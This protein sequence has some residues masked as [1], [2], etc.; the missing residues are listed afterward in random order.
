MPPSNH[1][2][3]VRT[4]VELLQG[5]PDDP[6]VSP[7]LQ[8]SFKGLPPALVQVC[9]MDP[10]RDDGLL[11]AEKLTKAGVRTRLQK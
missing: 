11:Y 3:R 1:A 2:E 4:A 5:P 9:G 8:P 7:L 6:D 10:L